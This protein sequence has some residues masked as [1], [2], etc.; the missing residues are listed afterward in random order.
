MGGKSEHVDWWPSLEIDSSAVLLL[1]ERGDA[2]RRCLERLEHADSSSVLLITFDGEIE[3]CIDG[4]VDGPD[5]ATVVSVGDETRSA[6]HDSRP[7]TFREGPSVDVHAVSGQAALVDAVED[8][9]GS[10][11]GTPEMLWVQG[12][13]AAVETIGLGATLGFLQEVVDRCERG[14]TVGYVHLDRTG[15]ESTTRQAIESVFEAVVRLVDGDTDPGPTDEVVDGDGSGDSPEGTG[16]E[17]ESVPGRD[18]AVRT[19][20]VE[21]EPIAAAGSGPDRHAEDASNETPDRETD[22]GE[23]PR[24]VVVSDAPGFAELVAAYL[25]PEGRFR[26]ETST[27]PDAVLDR[28]ESIDCIVVGPDIPGTAATPF[29]RRLRSADPDLPVLWLPASRENVPEAVEASHVFDRDREGYDALAAFVRTAIHDA[30]GRIAR[31]VLANAP[32]SL[33]SFAPDGTVERVGGA[34]VLDRVDIDDSATIEDVFADDGLEA[35]LAALRDSEEWAGDLAVETDDGTVPVRVSMAPV[36]QDGVVVRGVATVVDVSAYR[37]REREL[38]ADHARTE[39]AI[40]LLA[41]DLRNLM[42]VIDSN[43]EFAREAVEGLENSFDRIEGRVQDAAAL[44]GEAVVDSVVEVD[45]ETAVR[46]AWMTLDTGDATLEVTDTVVIYADGNLFDRLIENLLQNAV[47]HGGN[48]VTVRVGPVDDGFFVED[49]G[50]GIPPEHRERVFEEQ[51]STSDSTGLGLAVVDRVA[52]FHD[53]TARVAESADGGARFE[54]T[55][56]ST[57]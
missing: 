51:F 17:G 34:G 42:M 27:D 6:S 55:D 11:S 50:D 14:G 32:D 25:E 31:Q 4:L 38:E 3:A 20:R 47:V 54:F 53:W 15:V 44:T 36:T 8:E 5:R 56:V 37:E 23:D 49:D 33:V 10:E 26:V 1:S 48:D 43:L 52:E 22:E 39:K 45:L 46:D 12:L 35:G 29:H 30:D 13:G 18:A 16:F 9:L 24:V 7:T 28:L 41:H 2:R 21:D 40:D 19:V 57:A